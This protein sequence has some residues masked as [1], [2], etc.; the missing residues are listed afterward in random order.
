MND[1]SETETPEQPSRDAQRALLAVVFVLLAIDLYLLI[2]VVP[3]FK[4]MFDALGGE[5]PDLTRLV[6]LLSN[7]LTAQLVIVVVLVGFGVW[8]GVK[9]TE[10]IPRAIPVVLIVVL[11]GLMVTIPVAIYYPI[12][13]LQAAIRSDQPASQPVEPATEPR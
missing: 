6:L 4:T 5:L 7:V 2:G 8:V 12:M 9:F 3:K 11:S 10:R 13:Q 1:Q